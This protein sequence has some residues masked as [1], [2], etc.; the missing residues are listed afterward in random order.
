[1]KQLSRGQLKLSTDDAGTVYI[2]WDKIVAVTT[3]LQYEVVTTN[4]TRYAGVLAPASTTHLKVV[5]EDGTET[6]LPFLDVVSFASLKEGFFERIDGT[7]DVGGSYTKLSGVGQVTR[8]GR[9]RA[10]G[11]ARLT[12]EL[13][14]DFIAAI[15]AYDTF[16]SQ[17][18]VAGVSR[19]DVGVSFSI[20]WTF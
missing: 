11:N 1:V 3:A 15:T 4:G 16:D 8:W 14:R 18:Q 9:V 10:N 12:R 13:F 5:A 6:V 19:N 7:F 17:P 20:G 2:E